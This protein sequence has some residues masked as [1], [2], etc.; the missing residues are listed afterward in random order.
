M[1]VIEFLKAL[2]AVERGAKV[3][4]VDDAKSRRTTLTVGVH[5][6]DGAVLNSLD[7]AHAGIAKAFS[8][9]GSRFQVVSASRERDLD[10][11]VA[12]YSVTT[13]MLS[14]GEKALLR[15]ALA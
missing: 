15:Q 11:A 14:E 13:A 5:Y 7:D 4:F 2:K 6:G 1:P 8:I 10:K 3:R 12:S 9:G